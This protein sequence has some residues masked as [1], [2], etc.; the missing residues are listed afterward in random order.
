M[1]D[2]LPCAIVRDLLPSYVEGLTEAETTAAVQDHLAGCADCRKRYEAMTDGDAVSVTEEKE[3]DYLKAV[4]KRNGKKIALSVILT[5]ALVLSG[6]AAKLFWIG[7]VCDGSSVA[8]DAV[9]S[10]DGK[11]LHLALY[12]TNSGS[13]LRGLKMETKDN[14]ISIT[15]RE[16]LVSP[17]YKGGLDDVTVPLDGARRVEVFGRTV[18]QDGLLIDMHTVR[19]MDAKV[20]YVGDAPGLGQLIANMEPDVPSTMELQ[21][22]E[23]PYGVTIHFAD[24]IGKNCRMMMEDNAY[25]LL[26][27]VDNLG[28]VHWDDPGGYAGSLTLDEADRALPKLIDA[29]NAEHGADISALGGI[30]DYGDGAYALQLLRDILGE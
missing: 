26:A 3:V 12:E 21:T 20:Q 30:K 9:L 27:L 7:K 11:D 14:V 23:E 2:K 13:S 24:T 15:A 29:Y 1:K 25:I 6:V 18:W 5:V 8:I 17:L 4:R 28:E 16:V 22:A 10:E 19:L